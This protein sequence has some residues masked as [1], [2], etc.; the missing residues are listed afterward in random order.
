[1][2]DLRD[3]TQRVEAELQQADDDVRQQEAQVRR[4]EARMRH[5]SSTD[6]LYVSVDTLQQNRHNRA[7]WYVVVIRVERP[8][9]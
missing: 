4:I 8:R 2:H 9:R 6:S 3:L 1:M 5:L 7:Q